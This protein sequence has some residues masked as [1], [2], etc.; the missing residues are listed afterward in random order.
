MEKQPLLLKAFNMVELVINKICKLAIL[1]SASVIFI[2]LLLNI[3]LRA[4]GVGQVISTYTSEIPSLLLPWLIFGGAVIGVQHGAHLSI[5]MIVGKLRGRLLHGTL[6]FRLAVILYVYG[7]LAWYAIDII[8][9]IKDEYSAI[10][11]VSN[12]WVYTCL[13]AGF[14]MIAV[15][16]IIHY[17]AYVLFG[18]SI[19]STLSGES[20]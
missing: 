5:N 1:V 13:L 4:L 11:E 8:P 10:L 19:P 14:L 12:L 7:V 20:V 6:I 2:T 16:E 18:K 3:L 15:T 17:L 9:I